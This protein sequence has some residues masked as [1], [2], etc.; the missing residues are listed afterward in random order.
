[1]KTLHAGWF[2]CRLRGRTRPAEHRWVYFHVTSVGSKVELQ[3]EARYRAGLYLHRQVFD[4]E[5]VV[6]TPTDLTLAR[7]V[8][9]MPFYFQGALAE[10]PP[11]ISAEVQNG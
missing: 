3:R 8:A 2:R 9:G 1:M 10:V 7:D 6:C 5:P 4:V 11:P